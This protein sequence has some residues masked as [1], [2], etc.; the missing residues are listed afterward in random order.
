MYANARDYANVETILNQIKKQLG[1][2]WF[3]EACV[4]VVDV[5]LHVVVC[6]CVWL[7]VVVCGCV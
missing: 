2:S 7:H 6:G 5:W 4:V 1:M 3:V